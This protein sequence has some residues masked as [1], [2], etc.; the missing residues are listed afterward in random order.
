MARVHVDSWG[1][2]YRGLMPDGVLDDP[3]FV[4]ARTRQWTNA[5]SD[6]R[7]ASNRIAVAERNGALVGIAMSGP[8]GDQPGPMHLFVLYVLAAYHG[9]GAG[10]D[11]LH[12]V[13][14]PGEP[15]TLWVAEPNP[16]AQAF[17]RKH[18]F[19]PDGVMKVED[20]LREVHLVRAAS[21]T[22]RLPGIGISAVRRG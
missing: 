5:L 3:G 2:T 18:G 20:G 14:G 22:V 10:T 13:I 12:A 21:R 4:P 9:S 15:A 8:S 16:R 19:E 7:W 17:Y 1:E 11:L 6:E